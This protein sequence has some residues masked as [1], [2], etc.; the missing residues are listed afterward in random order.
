V[1]A[2]RDRLLIGERL[3][4]AGRDPVGGGWHGWTRE[5]TAWHIARRGPLTGTDPA[6]HGAQARLQ[7]MGGFGRLNSLFFLTGH[8][9]VAFVVLLICQTGLEPEAACGLSAECLVNPARGYVSVAYVKN[10]AHGHSRKTMRVTDGGALHHPG[11]ELFY[12]AE[13]GILDRLLQGV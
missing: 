10:R 12:A 9:V 3:A 4:A 6:E 1:R 5:N 2:A 13:G 7:E 11:G 8:D